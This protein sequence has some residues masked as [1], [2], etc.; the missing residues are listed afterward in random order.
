MHTVAAPIIASVVI[1]AFLRP[2]RSP[3]WPNTTPPS[4]RAKK[5]T[6]N[7]PNEAIVLTNG[8][9]DGK[10]NSPNTSAAAVA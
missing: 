1:S 2:I 9:P 5:P 8:S 10:Y 7:V 4:G 3:R 6:A